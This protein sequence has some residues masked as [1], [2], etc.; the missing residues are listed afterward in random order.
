MIDGFT[1]AYGHDWLALYCDA[2]GDDAEPIYSMPSDVASLGLVVAAAREHLA[3]EHPTEPARG[4]DSSR[5]LSDVRTVLS[6]AETARD[7]F[8]D[9]GTELDWSLPL[10]ERVYR[11]PDHDAMVAALD[12]VVRLLSRWRRTGRTRRSS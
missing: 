3:A 5:A 1:L 6:H 8:A 11:D 4:R 2:C 9:A 7:A 12:E 10:G